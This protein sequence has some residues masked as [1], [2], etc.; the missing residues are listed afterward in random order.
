MLTLTRRKF[1][2]KRNLQSVYDDLVA[3]RDF[4]SHQ[5][6]ENFQVRSIRAKFGYMTK[7]LIERYS[8]DKEG[9]NL[10]GH[11]SADRL[12]SL[13]LSLVEEQSKFANE[14]TEQ[15]NKKSKSKSKMLAH[16]HAA[17]ESQLEHEIYEEQTIDDN[18]SVM[19]SSLT[20]SDMM[21]TPSP[22]KRNRNAIEEDFVGTL[23]SGIDRIN[24]RNEDWKSTQVFHF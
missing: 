9:A 2:Y 5:D 1:H 4:P 12:T 15:N 13:L 8:F 11:G 6:D 17:F 24:A 14:L 23:L 19:M 18:D 21:K 7:A 16:E 22:K 3:D 20:S 10:S